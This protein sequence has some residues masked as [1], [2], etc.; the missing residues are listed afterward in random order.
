MIAKRHIIVLA[1]GQQTRLPEL[2]LPKQLL[3]LPA[4]AQVPILA[5]T[6]LMIRE[7]DLTARVTIVG[8]E[9]LLE[10]IWA[11]RPPEGGNAV[12]KIAKLAGDIELERYQLPDPGNSSLR[13]LGRYLQ[14]RQHVIDLHA[15]D[16]EI[17]Q[18]V[19]L[20]GDVCYSWRA[21]ALL[22]SDATPYKFVGT[23]DL[24]ESRG[25]LWGVAWRKDADVPLVAWLHKALRKHPPFPAYQCGQLRQ[26]LFT[27]K[28]EL[29]RR[30]RFY[31]PV[32]DFTKDFDVPADLDLLHVTS[33]MAAH[34]D[35][36]HFI[37]WP[38]PGS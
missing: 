37:R 22:F 10:P 26:W 1:Q 19:V 32:D 29:D 24:S 33:T 4:C 35:A 6:L 11:W 17:A 13:G 34:D 7:L 25:E 28:A 16:F 18:T 2:T 27:A 30:L 20:L 15:L 36:Q 31:E 12:N 21:M 9:G 5:R 23:A 3:P 8:R 38:S 14:Y